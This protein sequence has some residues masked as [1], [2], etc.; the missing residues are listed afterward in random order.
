MVKQ[1]NLDVLDWFCG[2]EG[3]LKFDIQ[4]IERKGLDEPE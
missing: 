3:F 4:P 2:K 1:L